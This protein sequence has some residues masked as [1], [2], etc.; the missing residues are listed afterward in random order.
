M[1][2]FLKVEELNVYP[3][4]IEQVIYFDYEFFANS[5]NLMFGNDMVRCTLMPG[6]SFS[7]F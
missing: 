6:I 5:S 1:L 4:F 3:L 7:L 2:G